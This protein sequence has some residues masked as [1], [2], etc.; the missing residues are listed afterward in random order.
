MLPRLLFGY[1]VTQCLYVVAKLNIADSLIHGKMH[2]DELAK[3]TST[4]INPLYRV[5]RCL[6]SLDIFLEDDNKCFSL[7]DLSE[8]LVSSNDNSWRDYI[9]LCGEELY[10]SAGDLLY[11]VKTGLPAFDH[12]Y[13]KTHWEFLNE[14]PEKAQIFQN[15]MER[16]TLPTL[17]RLIKT[18]DFSSFS[19]IV[20]VGG[21]KGHLLSEILLQNSHCSGIVFDLSSNKELALQF[22]HQK[23]LT[24]RC[25]FISGSFFESIPSGNLYLLKTI[26]HDWD[27][28]HAIV[29]L[30]NC[31][32]NMSK[33]SKLLIIDRIF[34][35]NENDLVCL[36]D[37]NMLV[38]YGSKERSENEFK[39]LLENADLKMTRIIKTDTLLSIIEA[40]IV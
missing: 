24:N 6:V 23:N 33:S 27:D 32:K 1:K 25:Q 5:M 30:K 11:S 8:N 18:F 38:M 14:Y 4:K 29:I 31:K 12:L 3:I 28:E 17:S 9:I 36:S 2:I 16:G 34:D 39:I 21:G 13:G 19:T 7:N 37:I 26:L 22:L 15:A 40:E 20:D 10:S 35:G